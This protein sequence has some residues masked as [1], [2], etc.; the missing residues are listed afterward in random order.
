TATPRRSPASTPAW[1]SA[2]ISEPVTPDPGGAGVRRTTS[3]GRPRRPQPP[4]PT[5][6]TRQKRRRVEPLPW[7][8][9]GV[10]LGALVPLISIALRGSRGDLGANPI[11]RVENELGLSALVFLLAALACTPAKRL[12]GWTWQMRIRRELG[13]FA[14]T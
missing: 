11:A 5:I 13:L 1:T 2:G 14:F 10:F 4:P 12:W 7:L 6:P 3:G 8:K 9:P